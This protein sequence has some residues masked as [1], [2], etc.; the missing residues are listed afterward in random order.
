MDNGLPQRPPDPSRSPAMKIMAALSW[1]D[2][3]PEDLAAL[4][5]NLAEHGIDGIVALDG[6]Y[7]QYPHRRMNS[8]PAEWVAITG[9]AL[10]A[11][12][13][14]TIYEAPRAW[15]SE[16]AKRTYLFRR[17]YD[18]SVPGDWVMVVDADH[19]IHTSS[20]LHHALEHVTTTVATVHTIDGHPT[21]PTDTHRH[22]LLYKHQPT[23]ITVERHHARYI[24]G[25]GTVLRDPVHHEQQADATDLPA[26]TLTL[27]HHPQQR[28][29][30]RLRAR[31]E[32]YQHAAATGLEDLT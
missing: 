29:E 18:R 6:A 19:S 32:Y 4:V 24:A 31:E 3:Q 23:G 14:H 16:M 7:A 9:A 25:D 2:E 10:D 13:S 28:T 26:D 17:V 30:A 1:F 22:R 21:N 20:G 15:A 27:W 12:I 8:S 11:G 5:T